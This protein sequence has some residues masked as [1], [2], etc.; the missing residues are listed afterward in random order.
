MYHEI[1]IQKLSDNSKSRLRNSHPV[2][3]KLHAGGPHK[4]HVNADQYKKIHKAHEKGK[5]VTIIFDPH[6]AKMHWGLGKYCIC[7]KKIR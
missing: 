5:A 1:N 3:V 6:Q 7:C 4:I 2:R